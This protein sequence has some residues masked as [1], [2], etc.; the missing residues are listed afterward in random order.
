MTKNHFIEQYHMIPHEEGG[1]YSETWRQKDQSISHI[2]Y[3]LPR[4]E[5]TRWHRLNSDE[6]WLLHH[7]HSLTIT[8]GGRDKAPI[9]RKEIHLNGENLECLIPQGTWQKAKAGNDDVLVSCVV[10]PAFRWDQWELY[11]KE[12]EK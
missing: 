9:P 4:G 5:T 6:L 2:Y 11:P 1:Y 7:G 8:L 10:S 12:Q 3:L